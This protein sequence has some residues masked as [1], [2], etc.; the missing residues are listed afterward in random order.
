M[1][2]NLILIFASLLEPV[3][4]FEDLHHNSFKVGILKEN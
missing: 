3:G 2:N 4:F 1:A